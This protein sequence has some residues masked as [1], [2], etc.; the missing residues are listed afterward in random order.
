M[1]LKVWSRFLLLCAACLIC[2]Q[3]LC[4]AGNGN[5][6]EFYRT[7]NSSEVY[8][9][10]SDSAKVIE[11]NGRKYLEARIVQKINALPG[12]VQEEI[13]VAFD[14]DNRKCV[15]LQIIHNDRGY[16]MELERHNISEIAGNGS[17]M[18]TWHFEFL[19]WSEHNL[20]SLI[21]EIHAF[22]HSASGANTDVTG[23]RSSTPIDPAPGVGKQPGDSIAKKPEINGGDIP[24]RNPNARPGAIEFLPIGWNKGYVAVWKNPPETLGGEY[25]IRTGGYIDG[26]HATDP[27]GYNFDVIGWDDD[28]NPNEFLVCYVSGSTH[29]YSVGGYSFI[30]KVINHTTV[31]IHWLEISYKEWERKKNN[32]ANEAT[33]S[34]IPKQASPEC[35]YPTETY[36]LQ[37]V[38]ANILEPLDGN[39]VDMKQPYLFVSDHYFYKQ[40]DTYPND[41]GGYL[42]H[43]LGGPALEAL[44]AFYEA[45]GEVEDY[46][47]D[48]GGV[49]N[50]IGG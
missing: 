21:N 45:G 43:S 15:E 13:T 36:E 30:A 14:I 42:K 11:W 31:E 16:R 2:M 40:K 32:P 34:P 23:P 39:G 49:G 20:P 48:A 7:G 46:P 1:N 8:Y 41:I 12:N 38:P 29:N 33:P 19:D 10:N 18:D 35:P 4:L 22:N 47:A 44:I 27:E 25:A 17:M 6:V 28:G 50:K 37:W 5:W 3:G 9:V 26:R 24:E